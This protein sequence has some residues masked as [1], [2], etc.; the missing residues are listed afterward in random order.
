MVK[1]NVLFG[2]QEYLGGALTRCNVSTKVGNIPIQVSVTIFIEIHFSNYILYL[3]NYSI[4][5]QFT[6]Q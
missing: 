3:F 5:N 4:T 1:A 2:M 6:V